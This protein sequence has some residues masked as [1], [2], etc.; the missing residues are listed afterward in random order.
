MAERRTHRRPVDRS[1]HP[2]GPGRARA[3]EGGGGRRRVCRAGSSPTT[4]RCST[5]STSRHADALRKLGLAFAR[6]ASP[7]DAP[8][9]ARAVAGAIGQRAGGR[10]VSTTPHAIIVGGGITGLAAAYR[11]T[12]LVPPMHLRVTVLEARERFRRQDP[13]RGL[14][15]SPAGHRR[16]VAADPRT[17][18]RALCRELG[19]GTQLMRAGDRPG[20][21]S[22]RGG[23]CDRCP[24]DARRASRRCPRALRPRDPV[25]RR[26]APRRA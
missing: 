12:R 3:A 14:R 23:S 26:H 1:R 5:T 25:A 17:A 18:G 20:H 7:N 21:S 11:L 6:T 4:W 8:E 24:A 2:R 16:G 13:H 9:L 22:G 15:R 10:L 19:L